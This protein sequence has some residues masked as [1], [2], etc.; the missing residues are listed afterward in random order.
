[1]I[2]AA[3]G[4][5]ARVDPRTGA[6]KI[7]VA[8][9]LPPDLP[10]EALR[11][12]DDVLAVCALPRRPSV[13]VSHLA[14]RNPTIERTF[15]VEGHSTRETRA[16]SSSADRATARACVS[17]PASVTRRACGTITASIRR[18]SRPPT[19]ERSPYRRSMRAPTRA[20]ACRIRARS[21]AG[22]CARR[23]PARARRRQEPGDVRSEAALSAPGRRTRT[24][25]LSRATSSARSRWSAGQ[26]SSAR[27]SIAAGR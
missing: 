9:R 25:S 17:R 10:C 4:D 3:G 21:C 24:Q 23:P 7:V 6:V 12:G 26:A 5:V 18:S 14:G 22:S 13:V 27:S 15:P 16:R 20:R 11:V 1:M 2:V 8:G 19:P